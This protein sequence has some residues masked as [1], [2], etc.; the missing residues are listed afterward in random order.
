MTPALAALTRAQ[1]RLVERLEQ[2]EERVAGGD[3]AAWRSYCEA[4]GALAHIL[5]SLAPENG[6]PL[7]TTKEMAARLNVSPKTLLRRRA[8]GKINAVQ[9]AKRGPGALRWGSA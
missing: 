2:L 5:P 1:L 4:A 9:L 7:L 3:E 8:R 6:G